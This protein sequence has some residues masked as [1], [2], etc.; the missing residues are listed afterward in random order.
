MSFSPFLE[1][2]N[3]DLKNALYSWKERARQSDIIIAEKDK[4]IR[5]LEQDNESLR[6]ERNNLIIQVEKLKAEKENARLG[7]Y[8]SEA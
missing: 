8:S 4:R 5:Q 1:A 6:F 3:K 2:Q 7:V